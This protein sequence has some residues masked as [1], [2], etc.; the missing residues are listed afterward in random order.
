MSLC[1][2]VQTALDTINAS[3]TDHEGRIAAL[4]ALGLSALASQVAALVTQ[5]GLHEQRLDAVAQA[6][7]DPT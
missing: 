4:E 7:A 6:A 3:I 2:E 1:T 5:V